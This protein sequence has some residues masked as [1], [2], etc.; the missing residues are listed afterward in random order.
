MDYVFVDET[1]IE[2]SS[3]VRN[4][5][6]YFDEFLTLN[7]HATK[8]CQT[9][10][11]Q[12]KN[13]SRI[14]ELL[15]TETTKLLIHSLVTSRLDYCNSLLFCIPKTCI[16]RLQKMQNKAA[17]LITKNPIRTNIIPILKELHWLSTKLH[18]MF[19]IAFM[20]HRLIT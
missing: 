16:K 18:A 12:L 3:V 14:R 1:Q 2:K 6:F 20:T 11:L 17:R 7:H 8:L 19:T 5:G 10:H 4:L 9:I 15:D 13:I